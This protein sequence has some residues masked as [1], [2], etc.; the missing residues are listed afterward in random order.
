MPTAA[1]K[2][3]VLKSLL[4]QIFDLRVGNMQTYEAISKAFEHCS[5][6]TNVQDYEGHLWTAL[7][8]ALKKPLSNARDLIIVVDGIDE[9][10]GG[11][12]AGQAFFEKLADVV[13][14]GKRVKLIGLAQS[15]SMPSGVNTTHISITHDRVHE[16]IHAVI[17]RNLA[18]T[19]YLTSKS[20]SEQEQIIERLAHGAN[21]SFVLAVLVSQ[22][23]ASQ[24]SHQDF[25]KLLEEIEKSKPSVSDIVQRVALRTELSASTKLI[26]SW[27]TSAERPLTISDVR[28]LLS[29]SVHDES[30]TDHS[31]DIQ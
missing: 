4:A 20:G 16:D 15:L 11:K 27:I 17:L 29:V 25:T 14:E 6:C 1:T 8:E 9:T 21:A 22:L 26:L 10:Q 18:H 23:L 28:K 2:S 19:H 30:T 24:K 7:E 5:H 31:P 13:C 12:S 3:A